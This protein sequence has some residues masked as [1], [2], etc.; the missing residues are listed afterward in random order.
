MSENEALELLDHRTRHLL[1][2]G[3]KRKLVSAKRLVRV[4]GYHPFAISLAGGYMTELQYGTPQQDKVF[5]YMTLFST[6]CSDNT[7]RWVL[8]QLTGAFTL[9]RVTIP[10]S[11]GTPEQ[12]GVR[13]ALGVILSGMAK[14]DSVAANILTI[15]GFLSPATGVW[16][17][18][19]GYESMEGETS[20]LFHSKD[21]VETVLFKLW[22][23]SVLRHHLGDIYPIVKELLHPCSFNTPIEDQYLFD[24]AMRTTG[25]TSWP[26]LDDV[27]NGSEL[28]GSFRALG[29]GMSKQQSVEVASWLFCLALNT[30]QVNQFGII[31]LESGYSHALQEA[32]R[33]SEAK[34]WY[35]RLLGPLSKHVG[36]DDLATGTA[37]IRLG[38]STIDARTKSSCSQSISQI[39]RA[40]LDL[41]HAL[42][43]CLVATGIDGIRDGNTALLQHTSGQSD[44]TK[45]AF[46]SI[47]FDKSWE[48]AVPT[49]FLA[50][51]MAKQV[52]DLGD[53]C[54]RRQHVVPFSD[55]ARLHE[56]NA[57]EEGCETAR[58]S[59]QI[60]LWQNLIT[61]GALRDGCD[62]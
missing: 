4:F 31:L 45:T 46:D 29:Q 58:T 14:E 42:N 24:Q 17:A 6:T 33:H 21:R 39:I 57:F 7:D 13:A 47:Y 60:C 55:T 34:A 53:A 11:D 35:R 16:P 30:R 27:N 15:L 5:S 36:P 23:T 10:H 20:A 9:N 48:Q 59:A 56:G 18:L 25:R 40:M 51:R 49:A 41:A 28:W 38:L 3:R 44:H 19:L 8:L 32:G 50:T 12:D 61:R 52:F 54:Q 22:H 1:H 43:I 37:H 2:L 26:T 62:G